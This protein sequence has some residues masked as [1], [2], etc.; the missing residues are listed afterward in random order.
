MVESIFSSVD[1]AS[2]SYFRTTAGAE[3]DLVIEDRRKKRYAIEIKRSSAPTVSRGFWNAL[4]E[5]EIAESIVVYPGTEMYPIG[6]NVWAMGVV[7][8]MMWIRER[9]V[10]TAT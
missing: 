9:T 10:S 8:A 6:A 7:D 2:A 5:L 1:G 4:E 3:L